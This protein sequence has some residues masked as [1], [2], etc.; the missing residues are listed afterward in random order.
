MFFNLFQ[1][2]RWGW[3]DEWRWWSRWIRIIK[4]IACLIFSAINLIKFYD[5]MQLITILCKAKRTDVFAIK[6]KLKFRWFSNLEDIFFS[7]QRISPFSMKPIRNQLHKWIFEHIR[8]LT[9]VDMQ[10]CIHIS[11]LRQRTLNFHSFIQAI[12]FSKFIS[13]FW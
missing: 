2:N 6:L 12:W 1:A 5:L 9:L 3:N 8:L 10:I 13:N 4:F 11:P 7:F